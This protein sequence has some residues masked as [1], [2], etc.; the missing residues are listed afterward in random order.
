MIQRYKQCRGQPCY[1]E[2]VRTKHICKSA[3]FTDGQ[4]YISIILEDKTNLIIIVVT[5]WSCVVL[6]SILELVF[7]EN[8]YKVTNF[9]DKLSLLL[10]ALLFSGGLFYLYNARFDPKIFCLMN[11]NDPICEG[12]KTSCFTRKSKS[13]F[14]DD[15]GFGGIIQIESELGFVFMSNININIQKLNFITNP[16]KIKSH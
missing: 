12:V 10:A 14:T 11:R 1:D 3:Y 9:D 13:V 2:S 15:F 4:N 8:R 7:S 6:L 16:Y 5:L